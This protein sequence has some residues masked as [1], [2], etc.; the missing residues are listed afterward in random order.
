VRNRFAASPDIDVLTGRTTD[1]SGNDSLGIFL[2]QDAQIDRWSVWK[3]GNSN[4][5]FVRRSVIDAGVRFR[6]ELGVG[7]SSPY[8]SGEEAA[9][10]LDAIAIGANGRFFRDIVV[11]HD[12]VGETDQR[13]ARKYARGMGRVLALYGYP[14]A[15]VA[16]R[17][18]RP[19]L[20]AVLGF[21]SLRLKF[22]RYKL[23]WAL[24]VYEGYAGKIPRQR[25]LPLATGR[26]LAGCPS[27]PASKESL[28]LSKSYSD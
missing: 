22:A 26:N 11:Y 24:G 16:I 5:I 10:L 25:Q 12:Q 4:T 8:Q 20:R 23:S 7:A 17:L 6:E 1:T 15:Y 9:F 21:T 18:L 2:E 19:A 3:A 27:L 14:R 13:R 28:L